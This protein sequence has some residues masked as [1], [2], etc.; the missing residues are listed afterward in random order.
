MNRRTLLL[1][2]GSAGAISLFGA[3]GVSAQGFAGKSIRLV[4][5]FPAGGPTDIVARPLAQLLGEALGASVITAA[6]PAVRWAPMQ[7]PRPRL[8]G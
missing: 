8:M 5:P 7:W 1:Y 6:A 3:S 4:V 2:A